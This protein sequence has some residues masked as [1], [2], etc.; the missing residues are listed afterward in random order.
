[1]KEPSICMRMY[2]GFPAGGRPCT[3]MKTRMENEMLSGLRC[4]A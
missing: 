4:C 3:L 2:V 1:M